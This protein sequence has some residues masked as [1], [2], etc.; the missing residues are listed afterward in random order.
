MWAFARQ[1]AAR[2]RPGTAHRGEGGW[3]AVLAARA[4]VAEAEPARQAAGANF[5]EPLFSLES[6]FMENF[7]FFQIG[8]IFVAKIFLQL[9]LYRMK[10]PE[11]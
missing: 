9:T 10:P 6:N 3:P 5:R 2:G 4:A 7:V 11:L 1:C 8:N